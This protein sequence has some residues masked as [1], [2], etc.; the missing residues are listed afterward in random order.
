MKKIH[1]ENKIKTTFFYFIE[2]KTEQVKLRTKFF[3]TIIDTALNVANPN[4]KI[5]KYRIGILLVRLNIIYR[6]SY[7]KKILI[8]TSHY[9]NIIGQQLL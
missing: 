6:P 5:I 9:V 7:T 8:N 3:I 2:F 4:W 1:V